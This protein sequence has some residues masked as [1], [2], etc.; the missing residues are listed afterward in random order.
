MVND[1]HKL[2]EALPGLYL[3]LAPDLTIVAATDAYLAATLTVREETIG[4]NVFEVFPDNPD[5][6]GAAKGSSSLRASLNSVLEAKQ[7]HTMGVLKY[8]IRGADG[9][10]E[11]RYW[12][13]VNSPYFNDNNELL[14]IINQVEDVTTYEFATKQLN[15][16]LEAFSHS[17]SHDLRAPLRAMTGYAKMLEEDYGNV[18]DSEGRRQLA[19]IGNNAEKMGVLIDGLLNF[20]HIGRK[21]LYRTNTDMNN[22]VANA[23]RE[24]GLSVQ[25]NAKISVSELHT[26]N[27]DSSLITQVM[28]NLIGNAIKYSAKKDDPAV[29]ISS[30]QDGDKIVFYVKDNGVG[31]DMR[32]ASKLFGV[33]QRLHS[34]D[35]FDGTGVGLAIVQRIITKHGG[36]V[37]AQSTVGEGAVFNF[38]LPATKQS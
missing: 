24:I 6:P 8:D 35:E 15:K 10:F 14:Y 37:G 7:P 26:I 34:V 28:V 9:I 18:L 25:H 2:F 22:L 11:E 3:I 27:A 36:A 21:N 12:M 17:V 16:E 33:F 30:E 23:I 20:S 32:Y 38:S 4:K 29:E 31:F 19:V 1:F 13:P 5:D